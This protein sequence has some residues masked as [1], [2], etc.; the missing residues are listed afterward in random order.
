VPPAVAFAL[1]A[2]CGPRW[3]SGFLLMFM[4]F[5][6][7]ENPIGD[8][9]PEVLLGI[10]IGAAGLGNAVGIALGSLMRRVNP[11]LVVVLALVADTAV[12]LLAALFYG[13]VTLALLGLTA[14]LAQALAKLSLD[15]TIQHDVPERVQSSAFARSDT[16][17]QLAWVLGGFLGIALPLHPRLGLGVACAVLAAWSLYVLASRPTSAARAQ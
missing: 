15:A 8:W 6:L 16:T 5:L 1:R 12:V 7:R 10:V 13:V 2:N 17:L 11:A 4:A 14:G 3:L 9:R